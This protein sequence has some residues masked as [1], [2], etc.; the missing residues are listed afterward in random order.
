MFPKAESFQEQAY[1]DTAR[2]DGDG[3]EIS[4]DAGAHVGPVLPFRHL[5]IQP[6]AKPAAAF[7]YDLADGFVLR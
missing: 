5:A 4:Q 1:E 2:C 6:S 3:D 7:G